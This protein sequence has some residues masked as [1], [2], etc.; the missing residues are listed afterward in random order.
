MD[1]TPYVGGKVLIRFEQVTDDTVYL[2]GFVLDD[3][4]IPELG[5]SDDAEGPGGWQ[6]RG[7][8]RIDNVLTQSYLVQV[9]ELAADGTAT[10][11]SMDLDGQNEGQ[12]TLRGFGSDLD[13]AVVVVAPVAENTHRPA[14]YS[15][16]VE[17]DEK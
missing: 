11:R 17:P 7:F 1:L 14:R 2:D 12:V 5:F 15:L 9:I 16:S 6:A 4:S 8:E 13:H 10:V 3:I